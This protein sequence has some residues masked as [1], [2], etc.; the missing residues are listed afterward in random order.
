[1]GNIT[2]Y[3]RLMLAKTGLMLAS[4]AIAISV[5]ADQGEVSTP[6]PP[7]S[8]DVVKQSETQLSTVVV[9]GTASGI[10]ELNAPYAIT[11]QSSEK[12]QRNAPISAVDAI[13][14]V[15]GFWSEPSGGTG[16]GQNLYVRG[17]PDGGWYNVQLQ[18]DGL[19][20][21]DE[22]QESYFNIDNL[23]RLDMTTDRLETVAGG[24]SPI[25]ANNAP[26]GTVNVIS[27]W[28]TEKPEGAIRTTVG[29]D[30]LKRIDGYAS[31][32]LVNGWLYSVGGFTRQSDGMR[33]TGYTAD[34]GGQFRIALSKMLDQGRLDIDARVLDDRNAL[35]NP[36]PLRDPSNPSR[37]LS[38]WLDPSDGTLLSNSFKNR[39]LK[40]FDGDSITGK[41]SDLSDG[42]HTRSYQLG[43][44][45]DY[46]LGDS[47]WTL[48]NRTRYTHAQV[49]YDTLFSG[50]DPQTASGYLASRLSAAQASFAG[51]TR[52][53]YTMAGQTNSPVDPS[54]G[55]GLV[56]ESGWY[57]VQSQLDNVVNDSRFSHTFD[58]G[59]GSHD[60]TLGGYIDA[61]SFKQ[62]R[63]QSNILT[64]VK[65]QPDAL[66]VIAYDANGNQTGRV[67]DDGFTRYG[68]GR[69][70]ADAH[71]A[72]VS[73]YALDTWHLTDALALDAG[74]RATKLYEEGRNYTVATRDLGD[75]TTL[76]DDKVLGL[77]GASVTTKRNANDVAKTWSLGA[78]YQISPNATVFG[79]YTESERLP[80]L[81][82]GV[83]AGDKD[84]TG[85][86]QAEAGVRIGSDSFSVSSIAYWSSFDSLDL[87]ALVVD[88]TGSITTLQIQGST[89]TLGLEN[90]LNWR[91]TRYFGLNASV[92]VQDPKV[93]GLTTPGSTAV[94]A[95][96]YDNKQLPRIPKLMASIQ[97]TLY[98]DLGVP[99]ELSV[100]AYHTGKRYTDYSNVTEMPAYTTYDMGLLTHLTHDVDLQLTGSN[101]TN[102]DG[103]TEGNPRRDLLNGQGSDV[104]YGRTIFGRNYQ[105]SLTYHW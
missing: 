2:N 100:T 24:T 51:T 8:V 53:G 103:I 20:L 86:K 1:M 40:S 57:S 81:Q 30:G 23:Y 11:T 59:W 5:H 47:G 70:K 38:S 49:N 28:G 7:A 87:S 105:A 9:T 76:A 68:A 25:F 41:A 37:S 79:R 12:L 3:H 80:R 42:V 98:F 71:G 83:W 52:L 15:P 94:S 55:S 13:K 78:S 96:A 18:Q 26:G 56:V 29:S 85:V 33:E 45:L 69:L 31:G 72:Y 101:L 54:S 19:T 39:T 93:T 46:D 99:M 90:A 22:P 27:R 66:D 35:Y 95:S 65:N 17:L 36:I 84:V 91:P 82:N 61:Y 43:A 60:L 34:K 48:N 77:T 64:T 97:P 21:F 16:G 73:A 75:S 10:T 32:P 88:G 89:K 50:S 104:T 6:T 74:V 14:S 62:S 102:K 4:L 58:T 92:T 63:T 44:H 67:T